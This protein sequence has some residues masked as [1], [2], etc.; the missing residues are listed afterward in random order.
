MKTGQ[1]TNLS[2]SS[3]ESSDEENPQ[4]KFWK[5]QGESSSS[6]T[7]V[8]EAEKT[9][10]KGKI[11]D[12]TRKLLDSQGGSDR[13]TITA[14]RNKA[15]KVL[16]KSKGKGK[17]VIPPFKGNKDNDSSGLRGRRECR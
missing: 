17:L 9:A 1:A 14:R 15:K 5:K 4:G 2:N 13:K 8:A 16:S 3:G 7:K 10:E 11:D 6:C 12:E